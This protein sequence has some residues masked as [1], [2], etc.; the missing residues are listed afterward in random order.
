M[1]LHVYMYEDELKILNN[2][3]AFCLCQSSLKL[4]GIRWVVTAS[5][6]VLEIFENQINNST[7]NLLMRGT[8]PQEGDSFHL[9]HDKFTEERTKIAKS[10]N[11]VYEG[12]CVLLHAPI[13]RHFYLCVGEKK[14]SNTSMS[15]V[16]CTAAETIG[17]T[18]SSQAP[19]EKKKKFRG[20]PYETPTCP[21]SV[22]SRNF[23][24]L[25]AKWANVSWLKNYTWCW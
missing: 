14:N 24:T 12:S 1:V 21:F 10:D 3:C 23:L 11:D 4:L 20:F 7:G 2:F 13:Y 22:L 18:I 8:P 6:Q 19:Y 5:I 25:G 15:S 16:P 17:R 9:H